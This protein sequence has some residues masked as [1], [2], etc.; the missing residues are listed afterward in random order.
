MIFSAFERMVAM[1]YLRARRQEGF[2]SVIAGFSLLGIG[3]GVATLIIVMS[4][5][6]GFRTELLGRVL[7]LYSHLEVQSLL[8]PLPE[9]D[10][11]GQRL[12]AVPGVT[13]VMPTVEG[14]ALITQ[15]GTASGAY[16][17]GITPEDFRR[18]P[19]VSTHLIEGTVDAF[20]T[21]K[22]AAGSE[23]ASLGDGIAIGSRMARRLNLHVGD[24][25]RLISPRFNQTA[26]GSLPR[27]RTYPIAAIFD[28]G[29]Y[30]VDNSLVFM[31]LA[32]A[33]TFFGV[34][35]GYTSL[36]VFVRNPTDIDPYVQS[37][38]KAAGQEYRVY[39]WR[40]RSAAFVNAIDVER[41]VMF[42]I[43]S[44][45][46]LVAAFNVISSMIMLVKDKGRDIAILRTMGASRGMVLRIFFLTGASIGVVGTVF[47]VILGVAFTRNIEAIRQ[48]I[49]AIIGR[50]LFS[51]E[52]YLF[53]QIP[54]RLDWMEVAQVGGMALFL[55][56]AATV[57]PSWRAARLDPVEA[58]RYE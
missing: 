17:H 2:I 37:V 19:I 4:V 40:Q 42:L 6:N 15:D 51:A 52:I 11:V 29:M 35:N 47:G 1:R 50:D 7:G 12:L 3:L 48:F 38:G 36:E 22:E 9:N 10:A 13:A 39:D 8:G 53:T 32:A 33:Q 18:R 46:I 23:E 14:Q 58:L 55:S 54:A 5:M 30:E 16:V 43:L 21:T 57:Y 49:Q 31:P 28:V 25:L 26:F 56:F 34:A 27:A 20:G 24:S 45:I 41:N 44:L